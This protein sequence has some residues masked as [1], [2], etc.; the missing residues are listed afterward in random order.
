VE[1]IPIVRYR[2]YCRTFQTAS[3]IYVIH[4]LGVW[5]PCLEQLWMSIWQH[6]HTVTTTEVSPDLGEFAEI[7]D[8]VNV[9]MIP[10]RYHWGCN[11]FQTASH[12]YVIHMLGV[13][14]PWTVVDGHMAAHSHRYHHRGFPRFGRV[15]WNPRW[16]QCGNDPDSTL[17]LRL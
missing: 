6:T 15:G 14:T 13:W 8:D 7:L 5:T 12:I 9:K 11:I 16:C 2:W 17:S 1:R 3:H 10:I 4:V